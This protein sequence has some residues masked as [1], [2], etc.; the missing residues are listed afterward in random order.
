M[1][2]SNEIALSE[3]IGALSRALDVAE[4]EP[5]GHAVRSC[6]IGM[7]VAEAI[8]LDAD[9]RSDLFYALLLKDAGCSANAAHMAALF[10]ADDQVAKRTSKL[11]NWARPFDAFVWSLKTVAPGGSLAE[12]ATRLRAI[13][14]EGQVTRSLMRARCHRGAEIA[15]KLGFSG[16]TAE[17]IRALD[18]HWDGHGQPRG[19][20]RAE[21]PLEARILCLAQ[22]VE[23]FHA[24]AGARAAY[25]VA[26]KRSGE[27]FDPE[28]VEA[29]GSFRFD[30]EFWGSLRDSDVSAVE[31]PDRVLTADEARL[32][33]IAD[34]FAAVVDAKS[35]WTHEH[36]DRVC[37][38]AIGMA[39][40]M[41]FDELSLRALRRAALL[42]D[43]GKLSISSRILDKPGPLTEDERA[44]FREHP[45]LA[46]R[47]LGRVPSFVELARVASAHHE[48]LDGS[49]YPRGLAGDAL[50]MPMRVL[51]VAD[52][53]EALI[54]DRPYRPA[55]PWHEALDLMRADV[56]ERLD[57]QA[58]AAL[59][60][61][62]R[63]H[64]VGGA[65]QF[66]GER[67]SLRR[68]K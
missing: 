32:D 36:C 5:P 13:R 20:R 16:A 24:T 65:S 19:L 52:V 4:G 35:P 18:E 68:I 23:V 59:E 31:P 48:R 63:N 67:R 60:E 30:T 37:S 49:G 34:G 7:R 47:I 61:L 22:T 38:L 26:R 45:L 3:L 8:D 44:R 41:D 29:L 2:D 14:N 39:Q 1:A 17:A 43:L 28:L 33:Q 6:L 25:R 40:L 62:L 66:I 42:H 21:I 55:H 46:E 15:L 64:T 11:V 51:A 57:A 9:S 50:T 10:G 58:F 54:S 27:W 53:Y 12:R 56:P